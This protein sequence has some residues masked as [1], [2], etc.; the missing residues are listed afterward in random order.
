MK[1]IIKDIFLYSSFHGVYVSSI[2]L[3]YKNIVN[4]YDKGDSSKDVHK[5]LSSY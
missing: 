3:Y 5:P 2:Y 1:K 4:F